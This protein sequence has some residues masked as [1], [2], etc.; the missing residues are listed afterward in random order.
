LSPLATEF[1]SGNGP[2]KTEV[3]ISSCTMSTIFLTNLS[4]SRVLRKAP[5]T[6]LRPNP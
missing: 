6:Y 4:V 2:W 5:P 1:T 3:R